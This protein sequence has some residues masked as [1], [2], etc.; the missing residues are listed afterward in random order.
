MFILNLYSYIY[1]NNVVTYAKKQMYT[2]NK[3]E[4]YLG[5]LNLW[6]ILVQNGDWDAAAKLE[7]KI[8]PSDISNYKKSYQPKELNHNL[9]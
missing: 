9:S 4:S 1:Q 5:R 3:G 6:H 7:S 8:D 2:I